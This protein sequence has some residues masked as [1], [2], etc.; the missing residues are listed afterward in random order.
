MTSKKYFT[1]GL[2]IT[3]IQI[4]FSCDKNEAVPLESCNL[5]NTVIAT[6]NETGQLEYVDDRGFYL[7]R[8]STQGTYNSQKVGIICNLP[9]EFKIDGLTVKYRG[10]YYPANFNQVP[11]AVTYYELELSSIERA[12]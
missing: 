5:N 7:L 9:E 4:L 1:T 10:K 6:V 3:L 12:P 2:I 11:I 8:V